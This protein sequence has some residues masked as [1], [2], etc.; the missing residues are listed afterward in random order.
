MPGRP[1]HKRK[2]DVTKDD[3]NRTRISRTGQ[4]NHCTMCKKTRHNQSACPSKPEGAASVRKVSTRG[5]IVFASGGNMTTSGGNV[6]ARG[7]KVSARGGE[8]VSTRSGK[9]TARGGKV[10]ASPSTPHNVS[11]QIE[12]CMPP[13]GFEM[14]TPE[15]S[16]SIVRTSG[17]VRMRGGG[18]RTRDG[19]VRLRVGMWIRSPVKEKSSNEDRTIN[20]K[21]VRSRGIWVGS[22]SE[23]E[24][25]GFNKLAIFV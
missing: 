9:V 25:Y 17:N 14:S 12:M 18:V 3:G 20:G 16:S 6:S 22:K 2:R 19:V 11:S 21:V 5:E 24:E 1:P 7:G 4:I 23:V 10:T 8:V 13:P 15:S